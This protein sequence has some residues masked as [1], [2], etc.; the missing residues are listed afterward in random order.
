MAEN[1]TA[2]EFAN[3]SW[4]ERAVECNTLRAELAAAHAQNE[5]V[6]Q[7]YVDENNK[8]MAQREAAL[9]RAEKAETVHTARQSIG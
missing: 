3:R 8:L 7:A 6:H 9:A 1:D 5:L 2:L 4:N